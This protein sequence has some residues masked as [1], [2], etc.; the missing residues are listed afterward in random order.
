MGRARGSFVRATRAL[1]VSAVLGAGLVVAGASPVAAEPGLLD[2]STTGEATEDGD[3]LLVD[4]ALDEQPDEDVVIA[5]TDDSDPGPQITVTPELTFTPENWADPQTLTVSAIDDDDIEGPHEGGLNYLMDSEDED[6]DGH[7]FT[8]PVDITDNDSGTATFSH[9]YI[10]V[11]EG[12]KT[13][14]YAIALDSAPNSNVVVSLD[15][16]TDEVTTSVPAITF[17]TANWATP[18]IV[19]V[20][21][22]DDEDLELGGGFDDVTHV[23]TSDDPLYDGFDLGSIF[24]SVVDN[25][26][27]VVLNNIPPGAM[28]EEGAPGV[29]VP[30]WLD[31]EP[32]A[33]V[34]VFLGSEDGEVVASP[35]SLVFTP[36]N[37]WTPQVST[38]S[39]VDDA[40]VEGTVTSVVGGVAT[41]VDPRFNSSTGNGYPV[42]DNDTGGI[43]LDGVEGGLISFDADETAEYSLVLTEEPDDTVT[44]TIDE[45][46]T[47]VLDVEPGVLTFTVENWDTP[48]T[49]ELAVAD[50]VDVDGYEYVVLEHSFL[51][52]DPAYDG[53]LE[54]V[55][56]LVGTDGD[57]SGDE[58]VITDGIGGV[59][60]TEGTA[61][62]EDTFY[63]SLDHEPASTVRLAVLAEDPSQVTVTESVLTFTPANFDTPQEIHLNPVDDDLPESR[64]STSVTFFGFT[65]DEELEG[66]LLT[67]YFDLLDD[68]TG[69]VVIGYPNEE[70]DWVDFDEGGEGS[71]FT[72][73][74]DSAP[75]DDVIV[76][77]T[78]QG[79]GQVMLE[80]TSLVFTP[81]NWSTPQEVSVEPIDDDDPELNYGYYYDL[82]GVTAD[83]RFGVT[84]NTNVQVIVWDDDAG[85][86]VFVETDD[87]TEVEEGGATDTYTVALDRAPTADVTVDLLAADG[88]VAAG[89]ESLVFTPANWDDPQEVTVT[90]VDDDDAEGPHYDWVDH[91]VSSDDPVFG[92][93]GLDEPRVANSLFVGII[94]DEVDEDPDNDDD[95]VLDEVD[96]CP[97]TANANQ[98][99]Q[100]DDDI[101]DACDPDRDGDGVPNG[102]DNC[103]VN[104]DPGQQDADGDDIGDVCDANDDDGPTGDLDD[105]EI[106]NA[107]DNCPTTS[108][109]GQENADDDEFGNACEPDSDSDGMIDDSDNCPAVPN[110]NQTDAD[111]NDIGD[112][113]EDDDDGDGVSNAGDNCPDDSNPGQED[114]DADDIGDACEPFDND[115]DDDGSWDAWDNCPTTSNPDQADFDGNGVGDACQPPPDC[116]P[117]HEDGP[118]NL[119]F[120]DDLTGWTEIL[121]A[122]AQGVAVVDASDT[123]TDPFGGTKAARFGSTAANAGVNQPIGQNILCQDFVVPADLTELDLAFSLWTFDYLGWDKFVLDVAVLPGDGETTGELIDHREQTAWGTGTEL[124]TTDWINT[125]VDLTGHAGDTVRLYVS[126]GGSQDTLYHSWAY[127]DEGDGEAEVVVPAEIEVAETA[128]VTTGIDGSTTVAMTFGQKADVGVTRTVTC[129]PGTTLDG[130][131]VLVFGGQ[132]YP[133]ANAGGD[134]W[135]A[136]IPEE[137]IFSGGEMIVASVCTDGLTP[138]T[139]N[140]AVGKIVLYDPSGIV[141]DAETGDPVVGATVRLYKVPGWTPKSAPGD[142]TPNTCESNV[143]KDPGDDWSQVAP[144][145]EGVLVNA[146]SPEISPNVNPF[147]T[148]G[149]GYYGWDVA[150]GCWYVTVEKDGYEDLV[151]PVVGVPPEVTDLD[152]QLT[153]IDDE[154]EPAPGGGGGGGGGGG[155]GSTVTQRLTPTSGTAR[156]SLVTSQ[157]TVRVSLHSLSN[158]TDV[159]VVVI[160]APDD[161]DSLLLPSAFEITVSGDDFGSATV[162]VPYDGGAASELGIDERE[163]RLFHGA[164]DGFDDITSGVDTSTAEVCG[165][166]TS[167]SPF[168]VGVAKT[169]RLAGSDRIETALAVSRA[170]VLDGEA[171]AM[172][173]ARSDD[174]AD[175]LAGTPVAIEREGAVLLTDGDSL[176]AGIADE[177]ERA[178]ADDGEV[179]V[180]GGTAAISE[181]VVDAIEAR[182]H[183]VRRVAGSD[184]YATAAQLADELDAPGGVLLATGR[185]FP[186]ALAAGAAAAR[187]GAVVLLTD[188]DR[189]PEATE[190]WL[191]E[192]TAPPMWAIGG[193]AA[194][195]VPSAEAV[196][197]SDRYA[198]AVAVADRFFNDPA[199]VSVASGATFA[200]ALAGGVHAGRLSAPLLLVDPDAMPDV[201]ADWLDGH[202][203]VRAYVY[204]GTASVSGTVLEQVRSHM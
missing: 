183:A 138:V 153:P 116:G 152:L 86:V 50:D 184:R 6:W 143:S 154:E 147:I 2:F 59:T 134:Q 63:V 89:P 53:W 160:D 195:A 142:T 149:I 180:V 75:T 163:L 132:S 144:T 191:A 187:I 88:Q 164:D 38:F 21:A 82:L 159:N 203:A 51:S 158:T 169:T 129:P 156:A 99:D 29:A 161:D 117:V 19:T 39:A 41:S 84:F 146:V 176:S 85:E 54:T 55:A 44:V 182:G 140:D 61:G 141:S 10:S 65:S 166:T 106:D 168:A 91:A 28:L 24:V 69:D 133:M 178:L 170:A 137:E 36:E 179:I 13:A 201:V 177:L 151:S 20:S 173:L 130:A 190:S 16:E 95:G 43:E 3:D 165:E 87:L 71:S 76:G 81:E 127:L 194:A 192:N 157:G 56:V 174:Y 186:D 62:P 22:I 12:G 98:A 25:D 15:A 94:D 5:W 105:D 103:P 66:E 155:S 33:V 46:S 101:G 128:S 123:F 125:A 68:D 113:C 74:L 200:D 96:N 93:L 48:Q 73:A 80:P 9:D 148:N 198:T 64:L 189:L 83:P 35:N 104:S 11:T 8:V 40:D 110:P 115:T 58:L 199:I 18:R 7:T 121:L 145:S 135:A 119:G 27:G 90:A 97:S 1:V 167:F 112:A 26:Y 57:L 109:P 72:V 102:D 23:V 78:G 118:A 202:D 193:P 92:D 197:G 79:D 60:L 114:T 181:S 45:W 37:W 188:G 120:E 47:S 111:E 67:D 122:G 139:H 175:A 49:V 100:D 124:K 32:T 30:M 31:R 52:N 70:S 162:C 171:S 17:T 14:Q 150:M 108:N 4:I 42:L 185:N 196:A 204:G 107:D 34:T 131:P 126:A 136:T 172:V 77:L